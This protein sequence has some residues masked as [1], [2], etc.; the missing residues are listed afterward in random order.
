MATKS[1]KKGASKKGASKKSS[2]KK[3]AA[4]K[5]AAK[6]ATASKQEDSA[7]ALIPQPARLIN[8]DKAV[9]RPGFVPKTYFLIVTGK[10]PY[11]NMQ[12]HLDPLIYIM[13]PEFWGIRVVG[14]MIGV[15]IPVMTPYFVSIPLQGI[16]GKKGIE[17]IG[18]NKRLKIKVP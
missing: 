13:K 9:V 11:A 5:S 4:N 18:A 12:V 16:I 7:A 15:G 14:T 8:F 2:S 10:K 3:S 1:T 17:V 6:K